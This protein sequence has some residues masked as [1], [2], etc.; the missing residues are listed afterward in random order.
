MKFFKEKKIYFINLFLVLFIALISYKILKFYPFGNF[1][2]AISDA[3]EQFRPMIYDFLIK[4]KLGILQSFSFNN[5][6]GNPVY[7]NSLYYI[8]SP[9]NIVGLLFNKPE[10]MY[11][12]IT[13]VK[14]GITSLTIT[15]YASSKTTNKTAIILAA[16]SYCFCGWY[17][18]YYY[19]L[20]F[21]DTFMIFPLYQYGLERLLNDNKANIYILSLAYMI[22][23]NFYLCFPVCIYTILYFIIVRLFY[24]QDSKKEKL[25]SFIN[26]SKATIVVFFLVLFWLY[27]ILDCYFRMDLV[28]YENVL[29]DY[30]VTIPKILSSIFY[31]QQELNPLIY[32]EMNPNLGCNTL[33]LLSLVFYFFNKNIN[34]REKI[35]AAIVCMII[36]NCFCVTKIDYVLN[37]FHEIRVLPYRYIFIACFL[38]IWIFLRNVQTIKWDKKTYLGI[39]ITISILSLIMYFTKNDIYEESIIFFITITLSLLVLVLFK[40]IKKVRNVILVLLIILETTMAIFSNHVLGRILLDDFSI[41]FLKKDEIFRHSGYYLETNTENNELLTLFNY[42]LYNNTKDISLFTSMTY[43]KVI[44]DLQ[45]LGYSNYV[46]TTIYADKYNLFGNMMFNIKGDY[47]LEKIYSVNKNIK[48]IKLQ[49]DDIVHNQN[50]IAKNLAGVDNLFIKTKQKIESITDLYLLYNSTGFIDV[51]DKNGKLHNYSHMDNIGLNNETILY[52]HEITRYYFNRKKVQAVYDILKQNQIHY[53]SYKDSKIAGTIKVGEDQLIFTSIPYD[54]NWLIKIDGKKVKPIKIFDSLIGIETTSG[55]HKI[56][57]EY[58]THFQIPILI[59][60]ISIIIY[61]FEKYY[62]KREFLK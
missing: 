60:V 9:V 19:Y 41:P 35:F 38:E 55:E 51:V 24:Q 7:F 6:L 52:N 39:I 45:K 62:Q 16:I 29:R 44:Y 36:I 54:T 34:L 1:D 11:V 40:P 46:N 53:T 30:Y 25:R 8:A 57:M 20:A 26:I 49:E 13:M 48:E 3:R 56:S 18:T 33:I 47:Y 5:G 12:V 14:L 37:F 10:D 42:N 43:N 32:G 22:I 31:G 21:V 2:S 15:K 23:S 50:A 58:K 27:M 28:F 59:S 17:I 61:I 4:L